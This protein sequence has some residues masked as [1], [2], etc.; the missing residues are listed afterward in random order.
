[1]ELKIGNSET[2]TNLHLNQ[3]EHAFSSLDGINHVFVILYRSNNIYIRAKGNKDSGFHIIYKN[4]LKK[5]YQSRKSDIPYE[6]AIKLFKYYSQKDRR[7]FFLVNWKKYDPI[8]IKLEKI[9][10]YTSPIS[11][12]FLFCGIVILTFKKL[13]ENNFNLKIDMVLVYVLLLAS[14]LMLP[15]SIDKLREDNLDFFSDQIFVMAIGNIF[16]IFCLV[17]YLIFS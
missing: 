6:I 15:S 1:M 16:L 8:S 11:M 14:I 12:L 7:W 13:I 10:K 17:L 2:T 5:Q 4:N 3:I 9:D